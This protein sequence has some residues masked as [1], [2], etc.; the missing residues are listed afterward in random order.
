MKFPFSTD[1]DTYLSEITGVDTLRAA[2]PDETYFFGSDSQLLADSTGVTRPLT[3]F[4]WI[5]SYAYEALIVGI[6]IL[7]CHLLYRYRES[8][9]EL[10]KMQAMRVPLEKSYEEQS[11][12]FKS[13]LRLSLL[14]SAFLIGAIL[15]RLS[16]ALGVPILAP[17]LSRVEVNALVPLLLLLIGWI[18]S[19]RYVAVRLIGAVTQSTSFFDYCRFMSRLHWALASALITPF[20]LA[21]ALHE[22]L[23]SQVLLWVV[24][25]LLGLL[26]LIYLARSCRFFIQRGVSILQWFLYLCAVEIFPISLPLVLVLRQAA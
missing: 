16:A 19:Y 25:G 2:G 23:I 17:P 6:F 8:L 15:I 5:E 14:L 18:A 9:F 12:F 26:L 10:F 11:L 4:S 22:S 24:C 20:F 21:T 7:F 1:C 13:F 3:E